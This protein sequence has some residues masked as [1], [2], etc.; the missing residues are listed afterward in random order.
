MAAQLDLARHTDADPVTLYRAVGCEKCNGT[1]FH[2]RTSIIE[3][4]VVDDA[5]RRL[6]LQRAP[7]RDIQRAAVA[8][9]MRTMHHDGLAKALA[10]V[11][12]VEEVV[13][14]TREA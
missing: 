11:T 8:Q 10:G 3:T 6:I 13:R 1:G 12:T 2:G 7:A 4:L 5:V 14:V 9:G